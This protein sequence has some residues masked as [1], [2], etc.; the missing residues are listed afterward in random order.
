[1]SGNVYF[2][3]RKVAGIIVHIHKQSDLWLLFKSNI[4]GKNFEFSQIDKVR[5]EE[6]ESSCVF[7]GKYY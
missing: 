6:L 4:K 7:Q 1:M 5:V 3:G 2:L